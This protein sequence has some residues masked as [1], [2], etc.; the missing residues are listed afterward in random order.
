MLC[1]P[2]FITYDMHSDRFLS[3]WY[4]MFSLCLCGVPQG[5]P[6][7]QKHDSTLKWNFSVNVCVC[8]IQGEFPPPDRCFWD[9]SDLQIYQDQVFTKE[10]FPTPA[11]NL[12]A[13]STFPSLKRVLV[14]SVST[15]AMVVM[16]RFSQSTAANRV[17]SP[18]MYPPD[19]RGTTQPTYVSTATIKIKMKNDYAFQCH[20]TDYK[21]SSINPYIRY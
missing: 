9:L 8:P 12:P 2:N 4:Q 6:S 11:K 15:L 21:T 3:V 14:F 13:G 10:F 17:P 1:I 19:R 7:S 5:S 18:I 20:F 16:V